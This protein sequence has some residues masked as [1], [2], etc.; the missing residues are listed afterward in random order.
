M[1]DKDKA[2]G[3][4]IAEALKHLPDEKKEYFFG[5]ADGVQAAVEAQKEKEEE[6]TDERNH[7]NESDRT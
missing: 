5:Y 3:H 4:A 7:S 1:S 2:A 6:D